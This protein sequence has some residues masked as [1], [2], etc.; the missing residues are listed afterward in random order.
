[1]KWRAGQNSV[2]L[3]TLLPYYI[4][5]LSLQTYCSQGCLD[6]HLTQLRQVAKLV[7]V[8]QVAAYLNFPPE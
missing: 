7:E 1:M 5:S 3:C 4:V 8:S 6:N 2:L